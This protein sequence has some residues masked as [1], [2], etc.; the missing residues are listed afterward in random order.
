MDNIDDII[1]M[2]DG[3]MNSGVSRLSVGTTEK[4]EEGETIEKRHYGRCDVG[5]NGSACDIQ[6]NGDKDEK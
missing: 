2:I 1:K 3:K 6:F 4:A 5:E